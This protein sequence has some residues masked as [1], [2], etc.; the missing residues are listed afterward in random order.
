MAGGSVAEKTFPTHMH[1]TSCGIVLVCE[2]PCACVLRV[3]AHDCVSMQ[4]PLSLF[5]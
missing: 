5:S 4:C 1:G 3:V 2:V